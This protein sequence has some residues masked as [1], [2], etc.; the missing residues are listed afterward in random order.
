MID[1]R[2]PEPV[3]MIFSLNGKLVSEDE[4]RISPL[5]RG[6]LYGDGIYE[7]V[8]IR[9][10]RPYQ[11][12]KHL[13]RLRSSAAIIRV[14]V[15][16]SDETIA[17]EIRKVVAAN[18]LREA[19]LRINMSR[20]VGDWRLSTNGAT[21]PTFLLS[22]FPI[23]DYPRDTYSRGWNVVISR[24]FVTMDPVLPALAK[25]TNRLSL[26]LA[27]REAEERGAKEAILL[28]LQGYL[29]EG[30]SSNLFF[31]RDHRVC[32]PSLDSGILE[33]V[34]R[35]VV[36]DLLRDEGFQIREALYRSEDLLEADEAFLTFTTA[37][38]IPIHS[39]DTVV[40]GEGRA[41]PVTRLV[42]DRYERD[43]ERCT[44]SDG[45]AGDV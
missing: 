7:T 38:I 41:G 8:L 1:D 6:F 37:G 35:G 29:T 31:V 42:L 45:D 5:D 39:V 24:E 20:G 44:G 11:L 14:E 12:G 17:E 3:R 33:G 34:T 40:V 30:T 23:P 25:T 43:V 28:N 16:L 27:K 9:H 36:M 19:A 15:P 18:N 32:T 2:F 22:L 10:G 13:D 21:C 26:I 4:A